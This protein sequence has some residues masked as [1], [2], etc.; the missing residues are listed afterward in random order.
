MKKNTPFFIFSVKS[1]RSRLGIQTA[2]VTLILVVIG[3][4]VALTVASI[5]YS[6]VAAYS[7]RASIRVLEAK[8]YMQPGQTG[9]YFSV[10]VKNDGG[11]RLT[12]I[13]VQASATGSSWADINPNPITSLEPGQEQTVSNLVSMS[14]VAQG[15]YL[16]IRAYGTT[17]TNM[18]VEDAVRVVV[19]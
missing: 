5:V 18:L 9:I 2:I 1:R 19:M 12:N 10:K 7:G 17:P 6:N 16:L 8:A 13:K 15:S 3:I 4:A 14:N 11:A